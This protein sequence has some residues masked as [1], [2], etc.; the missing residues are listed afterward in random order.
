VIRP[1]LRQLEEFHAVL[2]MVY[3]YYMPGESLEKIR[4]SVEPLREKMAALNTA[5][6]PTRFKDKEGSFTVA[7]KGLDKAVTEFGTAVS[8]DDIGK[9]KNATETMHSRY[10]TLATVLE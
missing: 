6:L 4:T 8:S 2:Y 7:R 5:T 10:V 9:I 1:P 3:H